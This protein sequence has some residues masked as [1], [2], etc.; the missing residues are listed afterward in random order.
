MTPGVEIDC[1]FVPPPGNDEGGR[2]EEEGKR[3]KE[4]GRRKKEEGRSMEARKKDT[5]K[6]QGK[7]DGGQRKEEKNG[8]RRNILSVSGTPRTPSSCYWQ[9]SCL[10]CFCSSDCFSVKSAKPH[11][12]S[13][14]PRHRSKNIF[15]NP[16]DGRSRQTC[17]VTKIS[18]HKNHASGFYLFHRGPSL[19]IMQKMFLTP[20]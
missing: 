9:S 6:G 10:V 12:V 20:L 8:G 14:M 11:L 18:I 7:E 2:R 17:F 13:H 19:T 16:C 3:R 15:S 1:V 5:R 4:E